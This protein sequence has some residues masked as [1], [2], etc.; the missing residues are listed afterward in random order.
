[1]SKV[2]LAPVSPKIVQLESLYGLIDLGPDG[3]PRSTWEARTLYN[4]RL[5][6]P[7]Q[8]PWFKGFWYRRVRVNRRMAE[9]ISG[10]LGEINAR[11]TPEFRTN[12]R[13][14]QFVTCYC[15]GNGTEP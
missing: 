11:Y 15:I 10:V 1:M 12:N 4:L 5:D 9:A 8:S 3:V 7:L 14:A 13:Q 6:A 2:A